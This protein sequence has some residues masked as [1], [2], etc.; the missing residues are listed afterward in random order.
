MSNR[1]YLYCPACEVQS[2]TGLNHG[3][4][5]LSEF[6]IA[7]KL[8]RSHDP[9][10]STVSIVSDASHISLD[11][12]CFLE[13]HGDHDVCLISEYGDQRSLSLD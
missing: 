1:W 11:T 3:E 2:G 10:L 5:M 12:S 6:A 9:P 8:I 4:G 7:W 13:E